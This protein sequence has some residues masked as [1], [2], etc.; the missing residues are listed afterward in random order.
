VA[1]PAIGGRADEGRVVHRDFAPGFRLSALD[2][3]ILNVG[4]VVV[5]ALATIVGWGALVVGFVLGHFF[6]F[7]NVVR[8]SRAL[9]LTWAAVFAALA[10]ATLALDAPGWP[11]TLSV[12]LI[13]TAALVGLEM[14]KPSYHGAGWKRIN[15]GLPAW[16]KEHGSQ[17][18]APK[19]RT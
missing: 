17:L 19:R 11:V 18:D 16:W 1:G 6:L 4:M 13:A 14:R 7:C 10:A 2:V 12:S 15:P 3:I 8:M 5:F 9:E